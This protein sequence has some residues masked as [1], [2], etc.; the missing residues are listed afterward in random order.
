MEACNPLTLFLSRSFVTQKELLRSIGSLLE[1]HQV[2]GIDQYPMHP[3]LS[4]FLSSE[5]TGETESLR[6]PDH[7]STIADTQMTSPARSQDQPEGLLDEL[8]ERIQS[9]S[10][11]SLHQSRQISTPGAGSNTVRILIVGDW[12]THRPSV[13]LSGL[14]LFGREE[15]AMVRRMIEAMGLSESE[16]F[17]TNVIKCSIPETC[18]PT[19]QHIATCSTHLFDQIQLLQPEIICAMGIIATRLFTGSNLPLSQQRG[20]FLEYTD[21]TDKKY[22]LMATFHPVFL[23]KNP[24]MKK[25]VWDD[26]QMIVKKLQ[27]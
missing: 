14:E 24:E 27:R 5:N 6:A 26:L 8:T 20:T 15:D 12:L 18:Q 11:C 13:Q 23:L 10:V 19:D 1:Y 17:V 22:N 2:C 4:G 25:A 9:C 7:Q 21:P 3:G 16:V